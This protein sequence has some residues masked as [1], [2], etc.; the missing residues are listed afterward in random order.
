MLNYYYY[1]PFKNFWSVQSGNDFVV[2]PSNLDWTH[3]L[4]QQ[5]ILPRVM[6]RSNP[7]RESRITARF[8]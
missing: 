2:A 4:Q 1:I 6:L 8:H 5:W 3:I 7:R